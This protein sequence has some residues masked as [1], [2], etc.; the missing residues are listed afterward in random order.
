MRYNSMIRQGSTRSSAAQ[1]TKSEQ[2]WAEFELRGT[3]TLIFYNISVANFFFLFL[4]SMV[5]IDNE[6]ALHERLYRILGEEI[7]DH[8]EY[9]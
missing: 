8:S 4:S 1:R 7:E 5:G 2:M 6:H 3:K 9:D